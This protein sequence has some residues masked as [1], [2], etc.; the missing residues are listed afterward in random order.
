MGEVIIAVE[1]QDG[2]MVGKECKGFTCGGR[3]LIE[4]TGCLLQNLFF[5]LVGGM[6]HEFAIPRQAMLDVKLNLQLGD[7]PS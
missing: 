1:I 7:V 6:W 3:C 5:R 4:H 2:H